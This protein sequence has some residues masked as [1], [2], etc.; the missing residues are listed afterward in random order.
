MLLHDCNHELPKKKRELFE[1]KKRGKLEFEPV[2]PCLQGRRL[3]HNTM[4]DD[5]TSVVV[6]TPKRLGETLFNFQVLYSSYETL[7]Y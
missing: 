1:E 5:I 4:E 7:F 2:P 6:K 3:N